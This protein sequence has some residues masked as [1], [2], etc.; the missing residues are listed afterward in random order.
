MRSRSMGPV[1]SLLVAACMACSGGGPPAG[2]PLADIHDRGEIT[3]GAD[4]AGGEP[5]VYQDAQGHLIGFEVDI[6][7]A[8]ARRVG[9]KGRMGQSNWRHPGRGSRRER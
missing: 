2:P 5:Y 4:Q 1:Y 8:I 7:D 9:G 6:M 3:W